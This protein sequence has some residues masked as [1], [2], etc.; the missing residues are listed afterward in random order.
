M[1]T[2][3][4]DPGNEA[5]IARA[6]LAAAEHPSQVRTTGRLGGQLGSVAFVVP[7]EVFEAFKKA[8]EET[9]KAPEEEKP[10]P[11]RKR[12]RPRNT[13]QE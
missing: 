1:V 5:V 9:R 4:P 7:E 6:L 3:Y 12:G 2:V 8:H 13:E 10:E 11:A